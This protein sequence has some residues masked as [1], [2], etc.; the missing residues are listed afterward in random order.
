MKT[1]NIIFLL[2]FSSSGR[3]FHNLGASIWNDLPPDLGL[4]VS[5]TDGSSNLNLEADLRCLTGICRGTV[6]IRYSGAIWLTQA[7]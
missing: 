3:S 2:S 1:N 4:F 6:S 5:S 7:C